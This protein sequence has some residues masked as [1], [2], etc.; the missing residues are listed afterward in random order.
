MARYSQ[1]ANNVCQ[2]TFKQA[3]QENKQEHKWLA[4][5]EEQRETAVQVQVFLSSWTGVLSCLREV[6]G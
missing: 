3:A 1:P 6:T 5:A 4:G 2:G